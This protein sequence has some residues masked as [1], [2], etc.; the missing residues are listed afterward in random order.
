MTNK[1]K[2]NQFESGRT[3]QKILAWTLSYFRLNNNKMNNKSKIERL[4]SGRTGQKSTCLY[5][6]LCYNYPKKI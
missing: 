1:P 3:G 2:I 6:L 4:K 5:I